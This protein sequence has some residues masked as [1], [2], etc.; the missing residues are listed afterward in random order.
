MSAKELDKAIDKALKIKEA[1]ASQKQKCRGK[2]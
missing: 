1:L 2:K